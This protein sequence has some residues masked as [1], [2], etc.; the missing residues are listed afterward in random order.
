MTTWPRSGTTSKRIRQFPTRRRKPGSP[1]SLR[2]SPENGFC[3][4]SPNAARIRVRSLVG[5]RLRAFFAGPAR[6]TIHSIEVSLECYVVPAF[7]SGYPAAISARFTGCGQFGR[8]TSHR[9]VKPQRLAHEFRTRAILCLS[10]S[11]D[12]LSHGRRQRDGKGSG[13]SHSVV[14]LSYLV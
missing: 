5:T 11:L 4:I 9:Q 14:T 12:L 2:M 3:C 13:F 6:T 8:K 7:V 1:C 10:R